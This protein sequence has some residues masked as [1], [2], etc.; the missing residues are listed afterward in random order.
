MKHRIIITL[1][2]FFSVFYL[3][4]YLSLANEQ[5][6]VIKKIKAHLGISKHDKFELSIRDSRFKNKRVGDLYL[7]EVLWFRFFESYADFSPFERAEQLSNHIRKIKDQE[8]LVITLKRVKK[9]TEL[10]SMGLSLARLSPKDARTSGYTHSYQ[11]ALAWRKKLLNGLHH[12]ER[13][14]LV[15]KLSPHRFY[16]YRLSPEH[17]LSDSRV[18]LFHSGFKNGAQHRVLNPQTGWS[19]V[20][21]ARKDPRYLKAG[22]VFLDAESADAIGFKI[23]G[24]LKLKIE[25]I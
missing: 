21:K 3:L 9:S 25:E 10:Q 16:A 2:V 24:P 6:P 18:L 20:V 7:G 1:F 14:H 13:V 5:L 8:S 4:P 22:A 12:K 11:M 23:S 19:I 15:S 17:P